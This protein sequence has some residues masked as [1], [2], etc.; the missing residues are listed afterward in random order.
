MSAILGARNNQF[1]TRRPSSSPL[2]RLAETMNPHR[3]GCNRPSSY[4][5]PRSQVQLVVSV[6]LGMTRK[7][8]RQPPTPPLPPATS[9]PPRQTTIT[10]VRNRGALIKSV[11]CTED[12]QLQRLTRTCLR[13]LLIRSYS[14][15]VIFSSPAPSIWFRE[16]FEFP[17]YSSS[18][19][20]CIRLFSPHFCRVIN[21]H[22][23]YVSVPSFSLSH[24]ILRL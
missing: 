14:N 3:W 15:R 1:P 9:T 13:G 2:R 11:E 7:T 22:P 4:Q 17:Y 16:I 24:P 10:I 8:D 12:G 23:L 20:P 18:F 5:G 21:F 6:G 19:V